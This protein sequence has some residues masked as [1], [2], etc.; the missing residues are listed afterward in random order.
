MIVPKGIIDYMSSNNSKE[1][2]ICN[3][4]GWGVKGR[5]NNSPCVVV[6]AEY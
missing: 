3:T 6:V 2:C 1:N 4:H 5:G